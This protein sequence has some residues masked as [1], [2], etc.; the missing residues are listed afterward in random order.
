MICI[1]LFM[2]PFTWFR[3]G[4]L[5]LGGD[6]NRLFLYDP[7][8]YLRAESLFSVEPDGVGH[9]RPDQALIP[10]LLLLQLILSLVHSPY[11]LMC[12]L[13]A[14]KMAGSFLFTYFVIIEIL[15]P[16][17]EK[18]NAHAIELSGIIAGLWY[19]FSPSVGTN[20]H[21]ALLTHNQVFLN[22]LMFYLLLRFFVS[23]A[24]GYL[25]MLLFVTLIFSPNFSPVAP[26]PPFAFY[27]LAMVFLG[28]YVTL[29]RKKPLP[30]KNIAAGIC[31]F[32]G[33]HAF[34]IIPV[35]AHV[36]DPSSYFHARVF[37]A[38]VG[39]NEALNYFNAVL[40]LG[41][42]SKNIFYSYSDPH[43]RWTVFAV[44]LIILLGYA[45]SKKIRADLLLITAFFFI[46]L[47][48]ISAN[49]TAFG[50]Q[51]YRALFEIPGFGMFR[52]FYG[53][54]QWVY[55]F[56]YALL[57]GYT[58]H[59][60]FSK[61]K[62]RYA[63]ALFAAVAGLMAYSSWTLLSGDIFRT[64]H[65]GSNS[66]T[67]VIYMDPDY[68]K[69]LAFIRAIPDDGR[70]INFPFTDYIYQVVAGK[71][72]GA[73]IG[74]SPTAYLLGRRDFSGYPGIYP[75]PEQFFRLIKEKK[76]ESISGL[77]GALNIRYILYSADPKA[78]VDA[79]PEFP[80]SIIRSIVPD[81]AALA[82][83]VSRLA[84]REVFSAG[85][86]HI[87]ETDPHRYLP[88]FYVPSVIY[89]YVADGADERVESSISFD[90]LSTEPAIAY[91]DRHACALVP[92]GADCSVSRIRALGKPPS[93]TYKRVN[94]TK[95]RVQVAGAADN[96]YTLV[97]SD[98]FNA[99]WNVYVSD[100]PYEALPIRET[101][102]GGAV[103]E[104][105]HENVFYD[106]K[107]FK[108]RSMTSIAGDR[109]FMINGYANAWHI[110]PEDVGGKDRYEIIV[111]MKQQRYF[112]YSLGIS[113]ASIV[114]FLL[115]GVILV[116]NRHKHRG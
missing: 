99:D 82:D 51:I 102:L 44:P 89:P 43:L 70:F 39:Q 38:A 112:Y 42:V 12:L 13:N 78:Y 94:P 19:V 69:A 9:V 110:R 45:W 27:P 64:P 46:T 23:H 36:F 87:Y 93:L 115:Y 84:A 48:L 109:H 25:W 21:V 16:Y 103:S 113:V 85:N 91:I 41:K 106:A 18:L 4:E 95:Y 75:F 63:M 59:V 28:L 83:L 29:V 60:V 7:G 26:P 49:I 107:T 88:H 30:W 35:I 3:P 57:F 37:D 105:F 77:F 67:S 80:Y 52:V 76:Y 10:F 96:P 65:R 54:W 71:N 24:G 79:F 97:F 22:P 1:I 55:A 108:T 101:Y 15:K 66:V 6:S 34:H 31:L 56:F 116:V 50:L 81:N 72:D 17:R 47:F 114:I 8:A 2:L 100:A 61:M 92:V 62:M 14:V 33:M 73:Y 90:P 58:A 40:G 68:E 5:E 86:Y 74:V 111:E 20:M 98:A 11:V 32:A 53:Q 104:S